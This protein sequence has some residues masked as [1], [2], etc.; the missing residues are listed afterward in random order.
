MA[1]FDESL[2]DRTEDASQTRRD[3]WRDEGR[4]FQSRE[5]VGAL[6]LLAATG[7]LYYGGQWVA[8]GFWS[9]FE[10]SF[11]EV[12]RLSQ[13]E[14][15]IPLIM[16]IGKFILKSMF[17]I[18]GPLGIT[19]MLVSVGATVAQTGFVWTSKPMELDPQKIDPMQG[20]SRILSIDGVVEMLKAT[21]KFLVISV[22]AFIILK[23]QIAEA[24]GLWGSDSQS[25]ARFLG[26]NLIS[27]LFAMGLA[28]LAL[29]GA[30][31]AWQRFRYEQKIR[32]TKQEVKEERRQSDG[33]PQIKARIRALQRKVA[34]NKMLDD[35]KKADVVVTNPTHIAVALI[36][37]RENMFAPRVVAKGAD[38]M[39]ERI[40]KIAR[41]AGVP[42]VE[43]V[44]LARA[45]YKALKIGQFI[46]RDLYNAVAEVLAYVYRLKGK[47]QL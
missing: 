45:L 3:E 33:N 32:M 20:L 9:V 19:A 1:L 42:C 11:Q 21:L 46:S 24:G 47:T 14:W 34:Q 35:V 39:A 25:L 22:V 44:P 4:V 16:A 13:S 6:I 23:K 40:K 7:A 26:T 38:Y 28:M 37:D 27:I 31:Y 29:A 15:S 5:L 8:M 10:S 2:E 17:M 30:D 36:Y 41:E 12:Q 43:N 18:L